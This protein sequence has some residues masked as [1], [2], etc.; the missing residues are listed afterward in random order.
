LWLLLTREEEAS[1]FVETVM[2]WRQTFAFK[3][4]GIEIVHRLWCGVSVTHDWFVW[5]KLKQFGN[6]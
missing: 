4:V 3:D 1:A 2:F 5:K 6:R